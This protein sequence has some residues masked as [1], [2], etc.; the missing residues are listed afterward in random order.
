MIGY[1]KGIVA[2]VAEDSILLENN[3]IGWRI[4][5]PQSMI[6]SNGDAVFLEDRADQIQMRSGG[7]QTGRFDIKKYGVPVRQICMD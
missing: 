7:R 4:F 6:G 2:D 1:I 5:M 3:G